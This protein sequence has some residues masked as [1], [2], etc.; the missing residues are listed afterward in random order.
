VEHYTEEMERKLTLPKINPRHKD[1][2]TK[3]IN[4]QTLLRDGMA[5]LGNS[6]N[7]FRGTQSS[8]EKSS[9]KKS[10]FDGKTSPNASPFQAKRS[11]AKSNIEYVLLEQEERPRTNNVGL[12]KSPNPRHVFQQMPDLSK[13]ELDRLV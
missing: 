12:S 6:N 10:V 11:G 5:A 1:D 2:P 9:I 4:P 8:I 13:K 7:D 3:N